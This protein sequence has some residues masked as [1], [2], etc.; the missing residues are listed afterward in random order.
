MFSILPLIALSSSP[1][2]KRLETVPSTTTTVSINL[3]FM[4]HSFFFF[5]SLARLEY[6]SVSSLSLN[7]T[8]WH[9]E[10]EKIHKTVMSTHVF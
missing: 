5:C 3:T 10:M 8:L 1:F 2:S 9:A 4:F 7:F 6:L